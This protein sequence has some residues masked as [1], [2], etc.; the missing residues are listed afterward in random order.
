MTKSKS[1]R[2]GKEE[3]SNFLFTR[4]GFKAISFFTERS[5]KLRDVTRIACL[6]PRLCERPLPSPGSIEM[7]ITLEDVI[8]SN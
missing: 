6:L 8:K 7:N 1:E 4:G 3:E 2:T 5:C